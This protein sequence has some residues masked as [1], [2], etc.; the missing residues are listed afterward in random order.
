MGGAGQ[1][2]RRGTCPSGHVWSCSHTH[3]VQILAPTLLTIAKDFTP[4]NL[5]GLILPTLLR[6]HLPRR[7]A[8]AQE[9]SAWQ[10]RS[11]AP[12]TE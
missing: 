9:D 3:L 1:H 12:S 2:Q 8:G 5:V 10:L 7:P 11:G 6:Q 4:F